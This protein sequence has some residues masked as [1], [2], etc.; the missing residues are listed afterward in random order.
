MLES[1]LTLRPGL[2]LDRR[3]GLGAAQN[4]VI[5]RDLWD[6]KGGF[7]LNPSAVFLRILAIISMICCASAANA[8]EKILDFDSRVAVQKDGALDVTET[9]RVNVENNRINHGI[10]RDFPTRYRVPNGGRM[11][12]GFTFLDATLDGAPVQSSVEARGNG[13]RIRLGDPDSFVPVGEHS[14][15]IHYR[16]TRELGFFKDFD[17]LYWNVTGNGW[18]FP[19]D[20]ASATITLPS[21]ARFLRSSIYA[22]PYGSNTG[23]AEVT[24][25]SPGSISFATTAPLGPNEGL[26]VAAAFPKA[27]VDAPSESQRLGWFVADFLPLVVAALGVAGTALFLIYAYRR[28]GRDPRAGTVVPIFAPPDQ[29]SPAAM[30]YVVEQSFD[31]RAFA[32]ALVEAGVK[33]HI[34]LVEEKGFLFFGGDKFV[35]PA[36]GDPRQPLEQ[37]ELR[38]IRRLV[39]DGRRI[40]LDNE[41]HKVFAAAKSDLSDAFKKQFDGVVF[42]RNYEWIGYALGIWLVGAYA[43]ALA[44]L[45][46]EGVPLGPW[47]LLPA[48]ALIV[49]ALVWKAAAG[50]ASAGGCVL[51]GIAFV[52]FASAGLAAFI[53]IPLALDVGR[54]QP[55]VLILLGLPLVLSSLF[56]ISAPTRDG[57]AMLDRIAGF[58]QYLSITEAERLDRL[59]APKDTLTLFERYLP[60]A[61]ALGVENRWADRFASQLA[62][63]ATGAAAG[64]TFAW[65]SGSSS[66]WTDTGGFVSS[67]GSSL[68]SS[69][70]SASTA[71]GSSSGSGGGGFSGGGG[72]GGGGGGW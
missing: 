10:L 49:G 47:L 2:T 6:F 41:N 3:V 13:V 1:M 63:A 8:E 21:P 12:V 39:G 65:Y 70:S 23:Q 27:V 11:K 66:P 43:T 36:V 20:R 57:R 55:I 22:G 54:W 58:K 31:N 7:S 26:S 14:Y 25:Q 28:A 59:Q 24:S 37:P 18:D 17:E 16:A 53:A 5:P 56:W 64:Q 50:L 35:E 45:L 46:S 33:G 52:C 44:V 15:R 68:S 42:K 62:G 71:P 9:L 60:Y 51:K 32:A 48:G 29:L 4:G 34:R 40:E 72:G 61:I 67:L 69:I 38:A 30:R 19:I